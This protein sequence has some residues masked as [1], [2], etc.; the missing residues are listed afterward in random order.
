MAKTD[1]INVRLDEDVRA[2]LQR[3]ADAEDRSLSFVISKIC[4]AYV[5]KPR[6]EPDGRRKKSKM[7]DSQGDTDAC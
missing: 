1:P 5:G 3:Q 7:R 4:A 6:P 2:A